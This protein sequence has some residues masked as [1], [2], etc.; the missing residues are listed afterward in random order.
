[1]CVL[2]TSLYTSSF[3]D[4]KPYDAVC[5]NV[6]YRPRPENMI[7]SAYADT[8]TNVPVPQSAL[9]LQLLEQL[10]AVYALEYTGVAAHVPFEVQRRA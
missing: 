10:S 5:Y 8:S 4:A 6:E 9:E 1:M 3:V 7:S 2:V